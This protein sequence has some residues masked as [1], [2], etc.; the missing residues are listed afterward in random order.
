MHHKNK[1]RHGVISTEAVSEVPKVSKSIECVNYA[2]TKAKAL[3]VWL[4]LQNACPAKLASLL[5]RMG[6]M[7]HV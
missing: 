6:G 3:I 2:K 7:T 1:N 4:A 5:I